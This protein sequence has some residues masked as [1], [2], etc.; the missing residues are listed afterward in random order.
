L[1]PRD[2]VVEIL[3]AVVDGR[4]GERQVSLVL[5]DLGAGRQGQFSR[6][7]QANKC[8]GGE[9]GSAHA[10]PYNEKLRSRKQ[11][12][13]KTVKAARA[14]ASRIGGG[15]RQ[16]GEPTDDPALTGITL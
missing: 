7:K 16:S 10:Y 14:R 1:E 9:K 11:G 15:Y 6:K 12:D 4:V 13:A 3:G 5:H 8:D 2:R